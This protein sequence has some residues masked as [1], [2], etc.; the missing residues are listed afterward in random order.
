MQ[1]VDLNQLV[2]ALLTEAYVAKYGSG[3]FYEDSDVEM[4]EN[5]DN[6]MKQLFEASKLDENSLPK[7]PYTKFLP[8]TP[9]LTEECLAAFEYM[10]HSDNKL[11]ITLTVGELRSVFTAHAVTNLE[12]CLTKRLMDRNMCGFC[13]TVRNYPVTMTSL[14]T[15]NLL[16]SRYGKPILR[17]RKTYVNG[18][19]IRVLYTVYHFKYPN[20]P[21]LANRNWIYKRYSIECNSSFKE[22]DHIAIKVQWVT[23]SICHLDGLVDVSFSTE[24]HKFVDKYNVWVRTS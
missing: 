3:D 7:W 11:S 13:K 23:F 5:C 22:W 8:Y 18:E 10:A 15:F 17:K 2:S 19:K 4:E 6:S 1:P 21:P 16:F 20:L 24:G 9:N 12:H 14:T